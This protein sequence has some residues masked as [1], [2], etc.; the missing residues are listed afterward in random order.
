MIVDWDI[1]GVFVPGLVVLVF[2]ALV[3]TI[4][5]MRFCVAT[6]VSRLFAYWPF[7]EIA[8]FLIIFG[9]LMQSLPLVGLSS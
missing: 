7:V 5:T 8:T 3:A 1:G 4:A 9:L 6:G 2:I